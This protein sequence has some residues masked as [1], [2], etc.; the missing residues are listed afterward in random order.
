MH[1]S[2]LGHPLFRRLRRMMPPFEKPV[3][4]SWRCDETYILVGARWMYLYRAVDEHGQT[5]E[6]HLSRTRDVTAAKAF[7]RRALKHHGQA[8]SI[9]LNGFE[10]SHAALRLDFGQCSVSRRSITRGVFSSGSSSCRRFTKVNMLS[11]A[12]SASTAAVFR[13]SVRSNREFEFLDIRH[14]SKVEFEESVSE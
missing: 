14:I 5:V 4:R 10:P 7:F 9:T 3:G 2:P 6:S 12:D 1:D 11:P 13:R 8:R